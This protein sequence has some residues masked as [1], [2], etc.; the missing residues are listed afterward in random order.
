L[1]QAT[2]QMA[3]SEFH[4][5]LRSLFAF[6]RILVR[7]S[8]SGRE[9]VDDYAAH[10]EG[11]IGALAR[12]QE[13]LMRAP[14][15]GVDLEEILCGELLAQAVPAK[16]YHMQG[17]DIRI[18]REAATAIAM[19]FHELV[20]NAMT[21]GAFASE[22]GRADIRWA[23][24]PQDANGVECLALEWVEHGVGL[25]PASTGYQG[26]GRELIERMLPYELNAR[27]AF[28]FAE[29][30]VHIELFVPAIAEALIWRRSPEE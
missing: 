20:T 22:Q 3:P 6:L 17:P 29:D 5:Q 24:E 4:R 28:Q 9:S 2:Q 21:Y 26:F 16:R 1:P 14:Q 12:I 7:D 10:L 30:G 18:G 19:T 13:I 23:I 27:T 25:D 11:R 8:A 15:E